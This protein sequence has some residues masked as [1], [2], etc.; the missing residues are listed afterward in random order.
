MI[1]IKHTKLGNISFVSHVDCMRVLQR[2]LNR[3]EIKVAMSLG[4]N[5]HL[6]TY[7]SHPLPVGV[8]S[9]AEYFVY[10]PS[11]DVG[12]AE[13]AR[14]FNAATPNGIEVVKIYDIKQNPNVAGQ[15]IACDYIT[16]CDLT[17]GDLVRL[18]AFFLKNPNEVAIDKKGEMCNM[19]IAPMVL[20]HMLSGSMMKLRLQTGNPTLRPD[21]LIDWINSNVLLDNKLMIT[22]TVRVAHFLE[23]NGKLITVDEYCE[24]AEK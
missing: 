11:E 9:T 3:A 1:V 15:V 22:K 20:S 16:E 12:V 18:E 5:P 2:S 19:D 24:V 10:K 21:K 13:I 8:A 23:Y 7:C 4:Y 6:L 14:K 17:D